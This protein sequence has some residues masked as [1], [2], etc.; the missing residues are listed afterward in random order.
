MTNKKAVVEV[1]DQQALTFKATPEPQANYLKQYASLPVIVSKKD[2]RSKVSLEELR[3]LP[4]I[5]Q[6]GQ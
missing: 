1:F 2:L 4:P 5:S 3:I 6:Q